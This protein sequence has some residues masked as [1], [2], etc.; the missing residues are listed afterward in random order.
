[1]C[2][3][4]MKRIY[5]YGEFDANAAEPWINFGEMVRIFYVA[6]NYRALS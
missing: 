2:S 4:I 1:M 5:I 3:N 6:M